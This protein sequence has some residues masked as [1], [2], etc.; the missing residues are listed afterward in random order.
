MV[1]LNKQKKIDE[2]VKS[3]NELDD[4]SFKRMHALIKHE[5]DD[6]KTRMKKFKSGNKSHKMVPVKHPDGEECEIDEQIS[7]LIS[8]L[9]RNNIKTYNSCQDN[10][11]KNYIWI[12]FFDYQSFQDF[13][14]IVIGIIDPLQHERILYSEKHVKNSWIYNV[15]FN[16]SS[17]LSI[18]ED[19]ISDDDTIFLLPTSFS[20][21]FPKLDYPMILHI[22]KNIK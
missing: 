21:R 11:P 14:E 1:K 4:S 17:I 19:N 12:E 22:F 18:E 13:M 8:H 10:I 15:N 6:V 16:D 9:W 20:V 7:E 2:L 5:L 3:L